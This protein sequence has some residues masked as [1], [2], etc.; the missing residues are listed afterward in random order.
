MSRVLPRFR[1]LTDRSGIFQ[2]QHYQAP[3]TLRS[4]QQ[5]LF[6]AWPLLPW[7]SC[8]EWASTVGVRRPTRS[9]GAPDVKHAKVEDCLIAT[10][11]AAKR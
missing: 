8:R 1:E 6:I 4:T 9:P 5:T 10:L 11:K 2:P 3:V 7:C